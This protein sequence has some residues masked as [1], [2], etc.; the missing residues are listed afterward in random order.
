MEEIMPGM[1]RSD[2]DY[3]HRRRFNKQKLAAITKKEKS[4]SN[5]KEASR[6]HEEKEEAIRDDKVGTKKI[7]EPGF[8]QADPEEIE[9]DCSMFPT[10]PA[11]IKAL[12][13]SRSFKPQPSKESLAKRYIPPGQK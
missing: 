4:A 9:L 6:G 1:P 10:D 2:C 12:V 5:R 7:S 8:S 11:A 13:T 3:K